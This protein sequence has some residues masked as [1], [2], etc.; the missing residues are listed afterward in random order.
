MWKVKDTCVAHFTE[1]HAIAY[2]CPIQHLGYIDRQS[3]ICLVGL[4]MGSVN[5]KLERAQRKMQDEMQPPPMFNSHMP[6][7]RRMRASMAP[8]KSLHVL[9]ESAA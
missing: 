6:T 4:Y 3:Y 5:S 2:S 8:A 9:L 7:Q 1:L